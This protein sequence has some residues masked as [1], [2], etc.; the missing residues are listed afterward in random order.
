[1]S[2]WST[3]HTRR[4]GSTPIQLI[5]TALTI[6]TIAGIGGRVHAAE[7]ETSEALLDEIVAGSEAN[8]AL[9]QTG[10]ARYATTWTSYS[11]SRDVHGDERTRTAQRQGPFRSTLTVYFD[12]PRL[13]F[14]WRGNGAVTGREADFIDEISISDGE[15]LIQY[16]AP[17][18]RTDA[19]PEH[20]PDSPALRRHRGATN[21]NAHNVLIEKRSQRRPMMDPRQQMPL[22][23]VAREVAGWRDNP[24]ASLT[25][26]KEADGTIRYDVEQGVYQAS[27]WVSPEHGYCIVKSKSWRSNFGESNP[28]KEYEA[29]ARDAGNGAYVLEHRVL[30]NGIHVRDDDRIRPHYEEEVQLLSIDLATPPDE[31]L[32][33]IDGLDLPVGTQIQDRIEGRTYHYGM[34]G[35]EDREFH[36]RFPSRDTMVYSPRDGFYIE[37]PAGGRKDFKGQ[38]ELFL[39]KE[40]GIDI[41]SLETT[42]RLPI[43]AVI[44]S[45]EIALTEAKGEVEGL[46]RVVIQVSGTLPD[47]ATLPETAAVVVQLT[48]DTFPEFGLP[49]S[50]YEKRRPEVR[51]SPQM[52]AFGVVDRGANPQRTIAVALPQGAGLAVQKA[53][54]SG[55]GVGVSIEKQSGDVV[56]IRCQLDASVSGAVRQELLVTIAAADG[57]LEVQKLPI[58]G[59]VRP[60]K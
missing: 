50:V 9:I 14:E 25:A 10:T 43:K 16:A 12:Y 3:A 59:Y 45:R 47:N 21:P 34:P 56:L 55:R 23:S 20:A 49:V 29:T 42:G 27:S 5:S 36:A 40:R 37:A 8:L 7:D 13:R 19:A 15:R 35:A 31:S 57:S 38:V 58:S 18:F 4:A 6:A 1:M 32:F 54:P 17:N 24:E 39:N 60:A 46:E 30:R 26:V 11:Y 52:V 2:D 33:T 53:E 22:S 48:S 51:Y 28:T 41:K 44:A